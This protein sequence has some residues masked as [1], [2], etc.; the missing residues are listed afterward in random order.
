VP[1]TRRL[2]EAPKAHRHLKGK[3]VLLKDDGTPVG[4]QWVKEHVQAAQRR[5]GAKVLS[6]RSG[7][8]QDPVALTTGAFHLLEAHLLLQAR[9]GGSPGEGHPG[10]RGPR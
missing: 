8:E 3:R 9:A 6:G 4:K 1:L 10:A 2:A 5:S 7:G